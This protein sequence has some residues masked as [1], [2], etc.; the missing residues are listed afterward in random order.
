[1]K[2]I[3][4]LFFNLPCDFNYNRINYFSDFNFNNEPS[5][6]KKVLMLILITFISFMTLNISCVSQKQNVNEELVTP[7]YLSKV[8]TGEKSVELEWTINYDSN[9]NE[10]KVYRS[11]RPNVFFD[12]SSKLIFNSLNRYDVTCKD[13][14]LLPGTKYYYKVFVFSKE[15][16]YAYSNEVSVEVPLYSDNIQNGEITSDTIWTVQQSPI[17]VK[18]DVIIK[19][20]VTLTIEPGVTVR[21]S[22]ND[23]QANGMYTNKSEIIVRGTLKAIGTVDKPIIFTSNERYCMPGD[24]GCIKFENAQGGSNNIMQYCKILYPSIGIYI[25]KTNVTIENVQISHSVYYG[26]VSKNSPCAIKFCQINDIG[27]DNNNAVG[28][29]SYGTPN[30]YIFNS[31]ISFING[32]GIFIENGIAVIDHNIIAECNNTAI[33]CQAESLDSIT[34]NAIINNGIGI[35]NLNPRIESIKPDFNNIYNMPGYNK[36]A[37]LYSGCVGGDNSM[38]LHPKFINPNFQFPEFS[39]FRL[40]LTS[41][42]IGKGQSGKDIGLANPLKFG[43][44]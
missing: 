9:F 33:T 14:G 23:L 26:I 43:I 20:G 39:D 19:S 29:I 15:G 3:K 35:K 10:Y 13:Y 31:I 28:V 21:L 5:K 6:I 22:T 24:W 42:M 2:Q 37:V 18:G 4:I 11:T 44:K 7:V 34:N 36:Q 1:M 38:S 30:P 17:I 41:P 32:T 16:K 25:E 12:S 27:Q 40:E 8:R